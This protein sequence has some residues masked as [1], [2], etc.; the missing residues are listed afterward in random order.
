VSNQIIPL[1]Y[2][3]ERGCNFQVAFASWNR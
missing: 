2:D 3:R 1:T